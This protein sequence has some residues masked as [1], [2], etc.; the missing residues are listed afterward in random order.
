MRKAWLAFVIAGLMAAWSAPASA[1]VLYDNGGPDYNTGYFSD[2]VNASGNY[3]VAYNQF[4]LATGA[5]I[6]GI[7]W[8]GF[9]FP[10][11]TPPPTDP[12]DY[13]ITANPGGGGPPGAVL[14]SGV[15]GSGSPVDTGSQSFPFGSFDVYEYNA[16]TSI[17]LGAGTYYLSI[18]ETDPTSDGSAFTWATSTETAVGTE[19]WSI[20]PVNGEAGA[21]EIG[22]A[23]N[24][25]GGG[26]ATV[27]E[28]ATMT[29]LGLGLTGLVAKLS[30][31]KSR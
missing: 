9:Y 26:G 23:F 14:D 27:P 10:G 4:S 22:L 29:L 12:F 25:T 24:L 28:P 3:Y 7:E 6:T 21:A 31:R 18:Y 8:W 19:E 16:S 20:S 17:P 13:Y 11:N 2:T 5:T 15:L 1:V 30:R